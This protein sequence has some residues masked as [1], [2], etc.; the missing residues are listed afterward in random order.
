MSHAQASTAKPSR[1][2][3]SAKSAVAKKASRPGSRLITPTAVLAPRIVFIVIVALLL[4]FGLVMLF[5]ASSVFSYYYAAENPAALFSRQLAYA[6]AG[7]LLAVFLTFFG[8]R[9]SL[10]QSSRFK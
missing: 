6:V 5:S 2:L 10:N 4:I 7:L 8:Y 3:R 9:V 1:G